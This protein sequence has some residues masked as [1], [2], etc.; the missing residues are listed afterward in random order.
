MNVLEQM[1][2]CHLLRTLDHQRILPVIGYIPPRHNSDS[3]ELL[4]RES[5]RSHFDAVIRGG[6]DDQI[7]F[8]LL[9]PARLTA[10]KQE[11]EDH[12]GNLNAC[13]QALPLYLTQK[14]YCAADLD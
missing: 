7:A 9:F 11:E 8:K 2:D 12:S 13:A 14:S 5:K 10:F 1:A 6:W 3:L 4:D